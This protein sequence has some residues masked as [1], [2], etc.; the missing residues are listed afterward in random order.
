MIEDYINKFEFPVYEAVQKSDAVYYR[1]KSILKQMVEAAN[2]YKNTPPCPKH[3]FDAKLRLHPSRRIK[4]HSISLS[5]E[6][7]IK[8][9]KKVNWHKEAKNLGLHNKPYTPFSHRRPR[10]TLVPV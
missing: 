2:S 5:F 3:S 1:R 4:H 10:R 9:L 8:D 6:D 7:V